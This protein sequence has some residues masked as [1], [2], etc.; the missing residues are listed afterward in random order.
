MAHDKPLRVASA[1]TEGRHLLTLAVLLHTP[2]GAPLPA[3]PTT[4][5]AGLDAALYDSPR[6]GIQRTQNRWQ[7]GHP[8]AP[9]C[10]PLL[11]VQ[12]R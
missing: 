10:S 5:E 9:D 6:S 3:A 11:G 2:K 8:L 12:E 4:A 7:K 1:L